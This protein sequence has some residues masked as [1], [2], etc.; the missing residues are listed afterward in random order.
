MN[1][2]R[3]FT[4]AIP[5]GPAIK[6]KLFNNANACGVMYRLS[7]RKHSHGFT[8]VMY[9]RVV[10]E[11]DP[12]YPYS[13]SLP[14]FDAQMRFFRRWCAVFPLD[15]ILTC[16][17]AGRTL[18]RHC[19]ALTFDDGYRDTYTLAWPVLKRYKLP[20]TV[21][22]AVRAPQRGWLWP[23]LLRHVIRQTT[24]SRLVLETLNDSGPYAFELGSESHRLCA[25]KQL[26]SLLKQ[27][28]N[29]R[30]EMVIQELA[31]KLC[32][33]SLEQFRLE[34]LMLSW[35]ELKELAA[36]GIEIGSH[37]VTH[38][39]LTHVS[40]EEAAREIESSRRIIE[41]KLR[42]PVRHFAYPNGEFTDFS[43]EVQR[44][45]EAAGFRSACTTVRGI[46]R[47]SEDRFALKRI[48]GARASLRALVRTMAEGMVAG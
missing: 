45:V 9:H 36:N 46:N 48:N 27:L 8:I 32:H 18:P 34:G 40:G 26:D 33:I 12:Y 23:D 28:P 2:L 10:E 30:K 38:P 3:Q 31:W 44:C 25:V 41:E 4:S 6:R 47:L 24:E 5:G 16:L 42:I 37:T 29:N 43:P 21:Y 1:R 7:T 11:A 17:E 20:A 22:V 13:V 35:N 39:I 19:V 14:L 15:A